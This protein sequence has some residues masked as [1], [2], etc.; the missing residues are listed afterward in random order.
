[1]N[2]DEYYKRENRKTLWR[3]EIDFNRR[4]TP[5]QP[6]EP[7]KTRAIRSNYVIEL[8]RMA[9]PKGWQFIVAILGLTFIGMMVVVGVLLAV[10]FGYIPNTPPLAARVMPIFYMASITAA[11]CMGVFAVVA[12]RRRRI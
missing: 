6:K 12:P 10:S 11:L 1:M 7:Y 9:N 8:T 5:A 3:R 4:L 2:F